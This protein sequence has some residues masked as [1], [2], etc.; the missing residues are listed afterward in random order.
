MYSKA[1]IHLHAANKDVKKM[2]NY[3]IE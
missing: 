3:R 1:D 2:S